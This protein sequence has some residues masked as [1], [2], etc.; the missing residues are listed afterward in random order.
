M[1]FTLDK[2]KE[3]WNELGDI[4]VNDDMELDE[5]FNPI[6]FDTVFEVG[7]DCTDVWHWFEDTFN[8]SVAKDLMSLF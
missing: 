7:T 6:G 4:P 1:D 8:I 5:E 3:L 2:A